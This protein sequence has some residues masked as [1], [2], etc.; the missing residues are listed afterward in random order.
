LGWFGGAGAWASG[1]GQFFF[2]FGP[3]LGLG[4]LFGWGNSHRRLKE[5]MAKLIFSCH[6]SSGGSNKC[7][8]PEPGN[9]WNFPKPVRTTTRGC[10]A[11]MALKIS[12]YLL[13]NLL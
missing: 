6:G 12:Q 8:D 9:P 11:G 3:A 4:W 7:F 1:F 2:E 10:L 5:N 13:W